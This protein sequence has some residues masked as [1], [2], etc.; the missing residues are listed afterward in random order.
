MPCR[1]GRSAAVGLEFDAIRVVSFLAAARARKRGRH[2]RGGNVG[3]QRP[4]ASASS[5]TGPRI[6]CASE[7]LPRKSNP[8]LLPS[9]S[10]V[11]AAAGAS[12][13]WGRCLLAPWLLK[14]PALL[15][16]LPLHSH[17]LQLAP[18]ALVRARVAEPLLPPL[19]SFKLLVKAV[20]QSRSFLGLCSLS[21]LF[22]HWSLTPS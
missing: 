2:G 21:F 16:C 4:V 19:P 1:R 10:A 6:Y 17:E 15:P 8:H 18:T 7:L 12:E 9:L 20:L 5:P 13:A 3:V 11:T 22:T 14:P